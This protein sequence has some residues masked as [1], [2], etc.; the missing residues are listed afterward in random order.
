MIY[1]KKKTA[2]NSKATADKMKELAASADQLSEAD[3]RVYIEMQKKKIELVAARKDLDALKSRSGSL[4]KEL[5]LAADSRAALQ[6]Y[7]KDTAVQIKNMTASRA[8]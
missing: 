4:Q 5:W 7:L 3:K 1:K 2:Q 8:W 6:R